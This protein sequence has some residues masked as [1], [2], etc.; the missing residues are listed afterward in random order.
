MAR[1]EATAKIADD[2]GEEHQYWC[3]QHGAREGWRLLAALLGVAG[4]A[5]GRS[6]GALS[7]AGIPEAVKDISGFLDS[8]IDGEV[9]AKA[10]ERLA[11][12]LLDEEVLIADVL[13]YTRRDGKP[14]FGDDG[15][16]DEAFRGNYGEMVLALKFSL[17][18]NYGPSFRRALGKGSSAKL[19]RALNLL[20]VTSSKGSPVQPSTHGFGSPQ[21]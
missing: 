2:Y 3:I 18:H 13:K 4:G 19:Q 12:S 11:G 8:G 7:P 17:E 14:L 15:T 16:F 6:L 9:L 21:S 10:V 5:L 20:G 1:E